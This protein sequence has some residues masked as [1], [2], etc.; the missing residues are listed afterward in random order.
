MPSTP[1]DNANLNASINTASENNS[2]SSKNNST[3]SDKWG[4]PD[5]SELAQNM[6]PIMALP[7]S[8]RWQDPLHLI[9]AEA[10]SHIKRLVLW[11][12]SI[13]ILILII[14]TAFGKLDIIA[15]AEG[16]LVPQTLVK[17]VQPA[18]PGVVKKILVNEGHSVKAG[19]LL[20][21]LDTTLAN[22]DRNG[23][24]KDIDIQRMQIRRINAELA[25]Q[26]MAS[27]AGDD[28]Q[29]YAQ[30]QR[31]FLAHRQAFLSSLDQEKSLVIKATHEYRSAVQ[32]SAKLKQTLPL[33][34]RS[35]EAYAKLEK[36]G[37]VSGLAADE[38]Q[39]DAIEK[40]RDLDAQQSI[41]ASLAATIAAQQQRITQLHDTYHA[42][43]QTEL[44]D[45][46]AR[47]AQLQPNLD[48]SIYKQGL[49]ELRAPQ[50]GVINDLATTTVGA[51]VQPGTVIMTLVP[52]DEQLYADVSVKNEDVGFVQIGQTAQ[53][54]LATYPF[55][56][57]GMLTGTVTRLSADAS[58]PEKGS[59]N[60]TGTSGNAS[61]DDGNNAR[62]TYKAR[63][64][65]AHQILV[66]PQGNQLQMTAGMQVV[67]EIQQGK[68]T[69]LEYL[70]SPVQKAVQ[71]AGRER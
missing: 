41:V 4:K 28:P 40:A 8:N 53:I 65:L 60:A 35:A 3:S 39:R 2:T 21:Q 71:E 68:R 23:V 69:V 33:Y 15:T 5:Q 36:E 14:W 18:E 1:P 61:G 32:I 9:E 59:T 51:V 47:L 57:Y 13:L 70:L 62:S 38:K 37:F 54:K 55:Q 7:S 27:K 48:K 58:D 52:Q 17:I 46:H 6:A 12:V 20:A 24:S 31:Q 10:P 44:A 11:T 56:K 16:K 50:D 67:A 22:A 19:Q 64:K 30:V 42:D 49:M 29:L 66:D 63:I 43:L 45:I 26:T 34:Q 25:D